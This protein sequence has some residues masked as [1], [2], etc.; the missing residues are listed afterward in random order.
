MK[1][2]PIFPTFLFARGECLPPYKGGL[3]LGFQLGIQLL[4]NWYSTGRRVFD[5]VKCRRGARMATLASTAALGRRRPDSAWRTSSIKTGS[6]RGAANERPPARQARPRQGSVTS[7]QGTQLRFG[8]LMSRGGRR[9]LRQQASTPR[10]PAPSA[11]ARE[12]W[13]QGLRVHGEGPSGVLMG[14]EAT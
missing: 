3:Q 11:P 4:F 5:W 10:S 9:R 8:Q 6:F 2:V 13:E 1:E 12:R 7:L 14:E